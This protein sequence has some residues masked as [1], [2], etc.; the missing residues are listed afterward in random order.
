MKK[1]KI[2]VIEGADGSGKQLQSQLL[3]KALEEKGEKVK[4]QSFPNYQSASSA[5]VKMYLGGELSA[6]ANEIDAYQS[7]VLFAVDR[8]CTMKQL[9]NFINDGGTLILD[10]YVQSNMF[11]QACKIIDE[12]ECDKFLDWINN[13]EFGLLKLPKPDVVF[14]LDVPPQVSKKLREERNINKNGQKTDIHETDQEHL[15]KAYN[16][17]IKVSEKFRWQKIHCVDNNNNIETPNT[18]H[19]KIMEIVNKI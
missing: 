16:T 12:K 2:I 18:I 5:P 19:K 11:H 6:T 4:L 1:G 8:L 9:E 3:F 10:R 17:G 15:I 7:S 14:F 13:F